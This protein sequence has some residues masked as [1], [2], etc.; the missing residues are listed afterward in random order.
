MFRSLVS[1][2][3]LDSDLAAGAGLAGFR[4]DRVTDSIHGMGGLAG[5]SARSVSAT[6]TAAALLLCTVARDFQT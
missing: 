4:W 3:D 2:G 1:V 6:S 5:A